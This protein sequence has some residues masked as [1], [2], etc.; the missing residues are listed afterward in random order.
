MSLLLSLGIKIDLADQR[1]VLTED[2]KKLA[3]ELGVS[4]QETSAKAGLN[5]K[6]LFRT[7]A[8]NLPGG[9][10]AH[11]REQDNNIQLQDEERK[12]LKEDEDA[13]GKGKC[14]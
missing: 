5:I 10:D 6:S 13:K 4:F 2:G 7:L 11:N 8:D 14:C 12:K 9:E 3:E 1:D